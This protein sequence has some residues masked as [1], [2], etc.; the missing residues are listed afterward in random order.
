VDKGL[1]L[2]GV[3]TGAHGIKGEVKLR[4]FTADPRSIAS[5][6]PLTSQHGETLEIIRLKQA[7][8]DFICVLKNITDRTRAEALKGT[9][10]FVARG[11]LPA[12]AKN[13][14]YHHDLIGMPV[15]LGDGSRLGDVAG[16]QNYGAGD[17]LEVAVLNGG[18]TVLI[19][20]TSAFTKV[21][22]DRIVADLPDGFLEPE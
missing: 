14:I 5:Y 19:P 22:D 4:S 10:L 16:V 6:G 18:E 17:L 20:L 8:D 21:M 3:I 2:L 7:N 1:V 15:H 13:E 9:E 11:R 12:A